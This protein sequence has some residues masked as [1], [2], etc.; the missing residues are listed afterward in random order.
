MKVGIFPA[1][2]RGVAPPGAKVVCVSLKLRVEIEALVPL[3]IGATKML[4]PE[5]VMRQPA[6]YPQ[7]FV[8]HPIVSHRPRV[9]REHRRGN[10]GG[11]NGDHAQRLDHGHL[12]LLR[13]KP[14]G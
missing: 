3:V 12:I 13:A 1:D 14:H 5:K 10:N 8:S 11:K 4:I 6:M 9:S 7:A 2:P